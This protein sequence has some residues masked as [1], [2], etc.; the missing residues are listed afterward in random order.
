MKV[1]GFFKK[2]WRFVTGDKLKGI[3]QRIDNMVGVALPIVEEVA[4][5]TPTRSDDEI[6]ALFK[7]FRITVEG[8]LGLPQDQRGAA[9]LHAATS[10]IGKLYPNVPV[11]QIQTAVQLAVTV[12]KAK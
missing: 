2:L 8:W 1:L 9:L 10:E 5:L 7:R 12:M 6:V 3:L 4:A 11:S